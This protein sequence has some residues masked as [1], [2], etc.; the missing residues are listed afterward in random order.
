MA[1]H[2]SALVTVVLLAALGARA[3]VASSDVVVMRCS[4]NVAA[5]SSQSIE[6][7]ALSRTA[8]APDITTGDPFPIPPVPAT[9][10]ADAL[11]TLLDA[12]FKLWIPRPWKR[13]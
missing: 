5:I 13:A 7:V 4:N 9:A 12:R 6:A 10:C 2:L 8:G 1:R 11:A 3:S